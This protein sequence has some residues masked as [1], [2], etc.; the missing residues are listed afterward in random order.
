MN[1]LTL[2]KLI[3]LVT[4]LGPKFKEVLPILI[5]IIQLVKGVFS[6]SN[7]P[8]VGFAPGPAVTL[9]EVVAKMEAEGC[10]KAEAQ[11]LVDLVK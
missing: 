11:A 2:S 7:P 5:E 4:I 10:D 9:D 6:E 8:P 1:L 3:Q